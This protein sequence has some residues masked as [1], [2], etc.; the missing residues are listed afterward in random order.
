MKFRALDNGEKFN[1]L[2]HFYTICN[3][4]KSAFKKTFTENS[5]EIHSNITD[6]QIKQKTRPE[7]LS[8]GLYNII[9]GNIYWAMR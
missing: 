5:L 9:I 4:L 8:R 1:F 7:K 2:Q 3:I 6:K